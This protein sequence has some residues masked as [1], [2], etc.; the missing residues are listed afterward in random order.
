MLALLVVFAADRVSAGPNVLYAKGRFPLQPSRHPMFAT[1]AAFPPVSFKH[2]PHTLEHLPMQP[3]AFVQVREANAT[4]GQ[5]ANGIIEL[6]FNVKA[7]MLH[8]GA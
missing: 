2:S 4:L 7:S 1:R 6:C 8:D 5:R 3:I